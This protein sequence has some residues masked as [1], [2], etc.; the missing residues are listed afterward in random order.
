MKKVLVILTILIL[1]AGSIFAE[2]TQFIR[3][4]TTVESKNPGFILK[5]SL[6]PN[7]F[8]GEGAVSDEDETANTIGYAAVDKSI[9]NE[10][11][12]VYFMI[13][14][15]KTAGSFGERYLLTVEATEMVLVMNEDESTLDADTEIRKT[16][17]GSISDITSLTDEKTGIDVITVKPSTKDTASLV[18]EYRGRVASDTPIATFAVTWAKD[19]T[20]P[21]GIYQASVILNVSPQ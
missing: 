5:A 15:K 12:V 21:D 3:V 6:N 19:T 20:I 18:A 14:Q 8:D 13:L 2:E 4:K 9:Q 11:V 10:D 16:K 1:V 17:K 7:M